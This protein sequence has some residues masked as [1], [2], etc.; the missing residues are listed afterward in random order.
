MG[1]WVGERGLV[2]PDRLTTKMGLGQIGHYCGSLSDSEGAVWARAPVAVVVRGR[3]GQ[4]TFG[5]THGRPHRAGGPG[6]NSLTTWFRHSPPPNPSPG[7]LPHLNMYPTSRKKR[8][9]LQSP[10]RAPQHN[11]GSAVHQA[12]VS[13]L[14]RA[15]PRAAGE[16]TWGL[17]PASQVAAPPCVTWAVPSPPGLGGTRP[18]CR[19]AKRLPAS[20]VVLP[21][22]QNEKDCWRRTGCGATKAR[23][24][25]FPPPAAAPPP[26]SC[27]LPGGSVRP[28]LPAPAPPLPA[29]ARPRPSRPRPRPPAPALPLPALAPPPPRPPPGRSRDRRALPAGRASR[30]RRRRGTQRRP[31]PC[32]PPQLS[33]FSRGR[34]G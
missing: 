9:L 32:S 31:Q 29:P 25:R 15:G 34:L 33:F 8:R 16:V 5:P 14:N 2:I 10:K 24:R 27:G 6:R 30:G 26:L 12:G 18:G 11:T 3:R 4:I 22:G 19:C 13:Q 23:W 1:G 20:L 17:G 21:L 28:P 7:T